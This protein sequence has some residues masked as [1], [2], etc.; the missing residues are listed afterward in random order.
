MM[1]SCCSYVRILSIIFITLNQKYLASKL[2][3]EQDMKPET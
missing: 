2:T 3:L 1:S